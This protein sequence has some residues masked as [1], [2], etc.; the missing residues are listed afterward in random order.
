MKGVHRMRYKAISP[1]MKIIKK[2]LLMSEKI[3]CDERDF[4]EEI[5]RYIG[6]TVSIF[7]TSGGQSGDAFT[8]VVLSVNGN[9]LRLI[10]R[11]GTA[12]GR[13]LD[14]TCN[15]YEGYN[16]EEDDN[17]GDTPG[18]ITDIPISRITAFVHNAV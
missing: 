17:R 3:I 9:I 1:T 13:A 16:D 8:G 4:S 14:N 10:T 11:I 6:Q 7:T 18:S 2:V 15:D 12:P 5:A